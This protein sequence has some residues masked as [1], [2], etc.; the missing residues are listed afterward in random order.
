MAIALTI[1]GIVVLAFVLFLISRK[2]VAPAQQPAAAGPA[3][4]GPTTKFHAVSIE[5]GSS[6]CAAAQSLEGKR[7]L[8]NAAPRIPLPDCDV[9]GCECR[10]EHYGDRRE[11]DT[12]DRRNPYRGGIA[13]ET[14]THQVEQRRGSRDRRGDRPKKI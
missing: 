6:V 4:A 7:F 14:G 12:D 10:F 5:V 11:T 3:R 13:G 9:P 8:S 1:F 2:G